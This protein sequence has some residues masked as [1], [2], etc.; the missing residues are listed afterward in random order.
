MTNIRPSARA[1]L[2][3][4]NGKWVLMKRTRSDVPLYYV[5]IGGGIEQGETSE[6][7]V[8]REL[9][10]E[11]GSI[12]DPPQFLFHFDDPDRPNSVDFYLCHETG[13]VEP[14]GPE[15]SHVDP[16]NLYEVVEVTAEEA[17]QLPLKPDALKDKL[18]EYYEK[19]AK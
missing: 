2:I 8:Q 16:N 3:R 13:H 7:A 12:V 10:E 17:R 11:T 14:N 6:Q 5:T 9:L 4:P 19:A 18:I 1:I 15:W